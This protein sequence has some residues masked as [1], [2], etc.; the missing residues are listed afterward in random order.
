MSCSSNRQ[1]KKNT[2]QKTYNK[3]IQQKTHKK[4]HIIP[5][6]FFLSIFIFSFYFHFFL[7]IFI[8]FFLFLYYISMADQ[9]PVRRARP[10]MAPVEPNKV[11]VPRPPTSI[12]V[13]GAP[14]KKHP[15]A[16]RLTIEEYNAMNKHDRQKALQQAYDDA[17]G[18]AEPVDLDKLPEP[19]IGDVHDPEYGKLHVGK[20]GILGGS[21]RRRRTTNSKRRKHTKTTRRRKHNSRK[22]KKSRK[23][24]HKSKSRNTRRRK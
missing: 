6:S 21:K 12:R 18:S 17:Y 7:S 19:P 14:K 20:A 5:T 2:Q 15:I 16:T 4:H 23:A 9:G 13:P 11:A 22:N 3:N 1:H 24:S 10:P 8:F